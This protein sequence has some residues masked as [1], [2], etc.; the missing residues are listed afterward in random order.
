MSPLG[1]VSTELGEELI[2]SLGR[3]TRAPGL[4]VRKS[5]GEAHGLWRVRA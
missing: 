4:D 2:G 1:G 3:G 5:Q